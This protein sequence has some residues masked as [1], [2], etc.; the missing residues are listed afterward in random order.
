[1]YVGH[2]ALVV[3]V[4]YPAVVVNEET[5]F[6]V[7]EVRVDEDDGGGRLEPGWLEVVPLEVV[8]RMVEA[9][10]D[11]VLETVELRLMVVDITVVDDGGGDLANMLDL[12]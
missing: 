6:L 5:G 12:K 8:G 1:M 2:K 11:V 10:G 7:V 4:G 3:G 9:G